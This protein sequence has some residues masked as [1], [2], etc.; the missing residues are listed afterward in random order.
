MWNYG[1][2]V[3]NGAVEQDHAQPLQGG[4]MV[5]TNGNYDPH[6][7]R[8]ILIQGNTVLT[9]DTY[10]GLRTLNSTPASLRRVSMVAAQAT[11]MLLLETLSTR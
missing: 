4:I 9:S 2:I 7:V 11:S 5:R 3:T 10:F 1:T 6:L 8:G